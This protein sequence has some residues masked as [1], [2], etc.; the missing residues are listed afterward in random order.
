M[1]QIPL[2][3]QLLDRVVF[4]ASAVQDTKQLV[5]DGHDEGKRERDDGGQ[6]EGWD[7]VLDVVGL[8]E[9]SGSREET[10]ADQGDLDVYKILCDRKGGSRSTFFVLCCTA[11]MMRR[12]LTYFWQCGTNQ[13]R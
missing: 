7:Q 3:E 8:E 9:D 6:E 1:E 5:V 11:L 12:G 13:P 10:G 2:V 4:L